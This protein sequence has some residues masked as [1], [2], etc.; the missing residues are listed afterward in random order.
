MSGRRSVFSINYP[1]II[2][3]KGISANYEKDSTYL[4]ESAYFQESA[5]L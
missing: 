4:K 1:A 5:Y 2:N 3:S